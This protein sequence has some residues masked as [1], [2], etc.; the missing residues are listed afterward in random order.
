MTNKFDELA[1][2]LAQS[3]TRRHALKKFSIGI[4]G[5]ALACFG[6][7]LPG[8]A[9]VSHLTPLVELSQPSPVSGCVGFS[10]PGTWVPKDAAEPAIT[11][12][13]LHPNNIVVDWI[14]GPG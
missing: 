9:Q 3:V 6:L 2:G 12:N 8:L 11:V 13:P 10:L 5:M 14:L 4:A 1:N 7:A